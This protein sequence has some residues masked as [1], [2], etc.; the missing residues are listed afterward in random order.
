MEKTYTVA[1]LRAAGIP[2]PQ[3]VEPLGVA[4]PQAPASRPRPLNAPAQGS[5]PATAKVRGPRQAYLVK[6]PA[7][8][9]KRTGV[10]YQEFVAVQ[11]ASL[12]EGTIPLAQDPIKGTP[13]NTFGGNR[14]GIADARAFCAWLLTPEGKA[15]LAAGQTFP[16][17]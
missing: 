17:I 12:P 3:S 14:L 5:A 1:Q 2:V 15:F 13:G 6:V 9:Q 11:T 7:G 10:A 8:V 16:T 4:M